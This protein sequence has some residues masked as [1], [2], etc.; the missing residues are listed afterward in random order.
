MKKIVT[1]I[2]DIEVIEKELKAST[3]GVLALVLKNDKLTQFATTFLYLNKNIYIYFADES[4]QFENIHFDS[5]VSFTII[6]NEKVKK[7]KNINPTYGFLTINILGKIKYVDDQKI[8]DD[9]R[10]NYLLKYK[11]IKEGEFDL[12][13][14]KKIIVIDSEEIHAVE[15]IGG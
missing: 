4:E 11:K 3:S 5:N 8:I 1:Q 15:E 13:P 6:K 12:S 14:L 9:L 10:Q 2:R 7:T